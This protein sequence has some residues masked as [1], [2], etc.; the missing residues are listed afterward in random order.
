MAEAVWATLE[1]FAHTSLQHQLMPSCSQIIAIIMDNASNN[2]MLMMSLEQWCQQQ[3]IVR[4]T[5]QSS[6][7]LRFLQGGSKVY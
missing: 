1:L 5:L 3:D 6:T 2:N 7:T 4:A